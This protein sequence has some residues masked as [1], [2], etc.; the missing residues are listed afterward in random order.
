MNW[1]DCWGSGPGLFLSVILT[2]T[3]KNWW[4][5]L[6]YYKVAYCMAETLIRELGNYKYNAGVLSISPWH[7]K[8]AK[9]DVSINSIERVILDNKR[10]KGVNFIFEGII[11]AFAWK[12]HVKL[13]ETLRLLVS[14]EDS[15]LVICQMQVGLVCC[16]PT[17][18]GYLLDTGSACRLWPYLRKYETCSECT[19]CE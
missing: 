5:L 11:L 16:D 14:G 1:D 18:N 8:I 19:S 13:R 15:E 2:V 3:C 17:C 12:D 10:K 6:I 7:L 4:K 9:V